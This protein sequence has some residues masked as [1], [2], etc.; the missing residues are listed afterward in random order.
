[1]A[2]LERVCGGQVLAEDDGAIPHGGAGQGRVRGTVAEWV[3]LAATRFGGGRLRKPHLCAV[4]QVDDAVVWGG[5]DKGG[6]AGGAGAKGGGGEAEG[7]WAA[8]MPHATRD[9]RPCTQ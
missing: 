8:V 6:G 4:V 9:G 7:V 5:R 1:M 3:A 2:A